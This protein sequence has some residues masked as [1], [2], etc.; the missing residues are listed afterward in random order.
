MQYLDTT[1]PLIENAATIASIFLNLLGVFAIFQF[2]E[3]IKT[4]K[5]QEKQETMRFT[6]ERIKQFGKEIIKSFIEIDQAYKLNK[7]E[8]IDSKYITFDQFKLKTQFG[9]ERIKQL[10]Q[11]RSELMYKY[12]ELLNNLNVFSIY[13]LHGLAD[14]KIGYEL[15][16]KQ[17][18]SI[19]E[20]FAYE[21]AIMTPKDTISQTVKLYSQWQVQ[22][23]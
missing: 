18:C 7:V 17:Y 14:S 4:R 13:F 5:G 15:M 9:E 2:R 21:I 22:C 20:N 11:Q 8:L 12:S 23:K 16:G 19:V 1:K 10:F 3:S 6:E